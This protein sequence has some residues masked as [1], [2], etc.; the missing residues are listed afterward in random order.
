VNDPRGLAPQGWHVPNNTEWD[1][2]ETTLGS[3]AGGKLKEAGTL[4]WASPN[5]GGNNNSG[6]A[7]L[8]GGFRNTNGFFNNLVT[9]GNWWSSSMLS[10]FG[11]FRYLDYNLV[12]LFSSF[13]DK[14]NGFYVRCLRD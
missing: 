12:N 11:W 8:P 14:Q 6:F 10:T 9:N 5:T 4:N 1:A 13:T 2:L 3:N 7:G